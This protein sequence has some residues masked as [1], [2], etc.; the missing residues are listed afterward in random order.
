[1]SAPPPPRPLLRKGS[2]AAGANKLRAAPFLRSSS[3]PLLPSCSS[4]AA[5]LPSL[6][7]SSC[8][9]G[10]YRRE[11]RW[12]RAAP[13]PFPPLRP[14]PLLL[15]APLSLRLPLIAA[16]RCSSLLCQGGSY[17]RE[18]R[19][20]RAAPP[21]FPPLRPLP[22]SGSPLA[23]LLLSLLLLPGRPAPLAAPLHLA[24]AALISAKLVGAGRLRRP[25]RPLLPSGPAP[26]AAP[27]LCL[28]GFYRREAR[29]CRAAPPPIPA[30]PPA[31]A[32]AGQPP[33][34]PR[35]STFVGVYLFF[36]AGCVIF[37][38]NI[39]PET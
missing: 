25:S 26:L 16:P 22:P 14:P 23:P 6:L 10:S 20:C 27:L 21:P 4:L 15:A 24:R 34:P 12:C 8:R 18:A 29:W 37:V 28:G 30:V 17:R 36:A 13:P 35:A 31:P 3:P 32:A 38:E 5:P 7:P 33:L 19:W 39:I 1:M 9:G 11:A 2:A